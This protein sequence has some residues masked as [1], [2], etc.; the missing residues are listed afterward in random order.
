MTYRPYTS[1]TASGVSDNRPNNSGVTINKA[2]PV[3]VNTL[4]ELDFVNVSV[5]SEAMNVAG[6]AS[7]DIL[8]GNSG[9]FITS[10]KIENVTVSGNFG[11]IMYVSKTGDLTNTKPSI[12]VGG[13]LEGDFI[14]SVGVVGKNAVTPANKDL[15]VMIDVVGQL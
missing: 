15:I 14:I 9:S 10:G 8:D 3:R 5:E 4:G 12:G 1:L 6:V 2:I 13:F 7:A 11:D